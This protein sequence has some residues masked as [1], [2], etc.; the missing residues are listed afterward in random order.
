MMICTPEHGSPKTKR[1]FFDKGRHEPDNDNSP[2][3][4]V[5]HDLQ[6]DETCTIPGTIQEDSPEIFPHPGKIGDG[7]DTDHYMKP[8]A[9]A[10]SE[11]LSPANVNPRSTKYD[12][13]HNPQPNCNDYYRYLIAN[14]SRYGTRNNYVHH[15][16]IFGK[17][18]GTA[19]EHLRTHS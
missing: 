14:L 1:L 8:D 6:G 16:W 3:V 17:C 7:I 18:Y 10:S 15:T 12:I 19:T 9:E 13:R 11:Q 4:T 5:R 2:E